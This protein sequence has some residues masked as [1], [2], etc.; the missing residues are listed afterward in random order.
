MEHHDH[1]KQKIQTA[2]SFT[3]MF[4]DAKIDFCTLLQI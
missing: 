3:E 1:V 4:Y 2:A